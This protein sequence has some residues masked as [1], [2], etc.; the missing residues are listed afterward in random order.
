MEK[1]RLHLEANF[2]GN[3]EAEDQGVD[4]DGNP[5]P[6]SQPAANEGS[7]PLAMF[8]RLMSASQN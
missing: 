1:I 6:G 2:L 4:A 5:I 8:A 7:D 3:R